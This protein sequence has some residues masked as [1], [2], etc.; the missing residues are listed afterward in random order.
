[1]RVWLFTL[2]ASLSLLPL[3]E[4]H[5]TETTKGLNKQ[6]SYNISANKTFYFLFPHANMKLDKVLN[7]FKLTSIILGGSSKDG[8][9]DVSV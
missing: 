4:I 2:L 7:T 6:S 5:Q 9:A 8:V 1:M 3:S